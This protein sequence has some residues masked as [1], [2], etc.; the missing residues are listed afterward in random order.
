MVTIDPKN[1]KEFEDNLSGH[2]FSKLGVTTDEG[3]LEVFGKDGTL[4]KIK[5]HELLKAYRVDAEE[6]DK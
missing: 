4:F 6:M 2:L 1:V 5:G 3:E